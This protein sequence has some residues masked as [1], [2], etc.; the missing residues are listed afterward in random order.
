MGTDAQYM[1]RK[2]QSETR[3]N[4]RR[5][6]QNDEE[7]KKSTSESGIQNKR[8]SSISIQSSALMDRSGKE[9][10]HVSAENTQ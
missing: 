8:D 7:N 9:N 3:K 2:K 10:K 5:N 6:A 4:P 1:E